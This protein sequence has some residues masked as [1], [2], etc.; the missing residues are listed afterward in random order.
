MGNPVQL[1][2][3]EAGEVA[4]RD[5]STV[6]VRPVVPAD[7]ARLCE[8]FQSLSP[9]SKKYRFFSV[10]TDPAAAPGRNLR[11]LHRRAWDSDPCSRAA[12]AACS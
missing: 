3:P 10:G 5:G 7:E 1:L 9:E 6:S 12:R 4:L 2:A 11:S 8:L